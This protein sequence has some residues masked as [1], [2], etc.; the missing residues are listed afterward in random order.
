MKTLYVRIIVMTMVIM[1][2]SSIIAFIVSNVYY[3]Y[4]L[5][6]ENDQ[7]MTNIARNIVDV[8]EEN[9]DR[10]IQQYLNSMTDLGYQFYLV[11]EAGEGKMYG[12]SFRETYISEDVIQMVIDGH[13]YHGIAEYPWKLFVTRSEERRVG[14]EDRYT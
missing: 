11:N 1:V 4:Y 12:D 9:D 8:Y 10:N 2:C 5:K 6:T 7:K 13:I 14:K 3:H